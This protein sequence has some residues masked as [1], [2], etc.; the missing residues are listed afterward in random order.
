M[1]KVQERYGSRRFWK[2]YVIRRYLKG[3]IS[4]DAGAFEFSS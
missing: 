2:H 3:E 1:W 4:D